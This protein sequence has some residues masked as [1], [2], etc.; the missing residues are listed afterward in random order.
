MDKRIPA[1]KNNSEHPEQP[2]LNRH[3]VERAAAPAGESSRLLGIEQILVQSRFSGA[4]G[5]LGLGL[6]ALLWQVLS[7]GL[8]FLQPWVVLTITA[9]LVGLVVWLLSRRLLVTPS[10]IPRWRL[11]LSLVG[12]I[13]VAGWGLGLAH[14]L[15]NGGGGVQLLPA[16]VATAGAFGWVLVMAVWPPGLVLAWLCLIGVMGAALYGHYE[17]LDI[18]A[19]GLI[20]AGFLLFSMLLARLAR[21][22]LD[23]LMRE[24]QARRAYSQLRQD[25]QQQETR[26]LSEQDQ[27]HKVEEALSRA[28]TAADGANQAKSEFLATMSH[29]IR[30]PLNGI[31]PIL[32]LLRDTP[33]NQEQLQYVTTAYNSSRHLLR[34]INDILDYSKAES[35]KLELENIEIE[36][37]ELLDSVVQLMAKSAELRG[38]RLVVRVAE[39]VPPSVRGDPIRLQQILTNLVNNAIKFTEHGEVRIEVAKR[40]SSRKEVELLFGVADSGVGMDRETQ[41]RLF[42]VFSQ[43]DAST[44]R[45]HG[46]TGLGLA[47]CKQ[48]VTL[49]GGRIGVR[50]S[51][52]V[53]STFWFTLLMRK[54]A[55]EVPASRRDLRGVRM[56]TLVDDPVEAARISGYL[57]QWG[58]EQDSYDSLLTALKALESMAGVGQRW[59]YDLILVSASKNP[60]AGLAFVEELRGNPA[61]QDAQVLFVLGGSSSDR[62]LKREPGLHLIQGPLQPQVLKRQ[63]ERLLDVEG[64]QRAADPQSDPGKTLVDLASE[65]SISFVAGQAAAAGPE[66]SA[67]FHGARVLLVEDNPVNLNVARKLLLK[68][69]IRCDAAH[70][71]QE[72]LEMLQRT[73]FDLVIMDCQMPVMDGYEATRRWRELEKQNG[74]P[75]LPVVA[76]TANAMGDDRERCLAA[77]MDDYLAKPVSLERLRTVMQRWLPDDWAP[78]ESGEV[79]T[80]KTTAPQL[81]A[82]VDAALFEELREVMEADLDGLVHSYLASAP[83]LLVQL[84]QAVER[85]DMEAMVLPAHSLKSSSANMGAMRA[86]E[87]ARRVEYAARNGDLAT[88]TA[89]AERLQLEFEAAA[90]E[91]RRLMS[92]PG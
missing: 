36:I 21:R 14:Y 42:R 47:I 10:Y 29:E 35:G 68:L 92:H 69:G 37:R 75:H 87:C 40:R 84:S 63:L 19:I 4:A 61:L 11:L 54:S 82:V 74:W 62:T 33:L 89:Q 59:M 90:V 65:Q 22:Y 3:Q 72:A 83:D 7:P 48:L 32:D 80:A 38:L 91:L 26:V 17:A 49:M 67:D 55:H 27:R 64:E 13:A 56:L 9:Q 30:T 71:G 46:G 88:A 28:Y 60:G 45:K 51:P 57:N 86:S 34:I 39:N 50:S 6:L 53:G 79:A 43:A 70:H 52:G 58:I 81:Q 8:A 31:L 23:L 15:A 20:A 85:Q 76:I 77:G 25:L 24:R 41:R 16:L 5:L 12:A 78:R 73:R 1:Q 44:T 2:Q 18:P 66:T